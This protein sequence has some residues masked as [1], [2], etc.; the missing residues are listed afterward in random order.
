MVHINLFVWWYLKRVLCFE[1]NY[2]GRLDLV[3]IFRVLTN[4]SENAWVLFSG[5]SYDYSNFTNYEWC[6][7]LLENN[8]WFFNSPKDMIFQL[9]KW[10]D[11]STLQL[12]KFEFFPRE[13]PKEY[14][15]ERRFNL[16]MNS[17][18]NVVSLWGA[19]MHL[20]AKKRC[21]D[22]LQFIYLEYFAA[23]SCNCQEW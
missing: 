5:M 7:L 10:Y 22:S 17:L 13:T 19:L 20:C 14:K 15:E 9:S 6:F 2:T 8:L 16:V 23:E 18:K 1:K 11:F 3:V 4:E 21:S 12:K